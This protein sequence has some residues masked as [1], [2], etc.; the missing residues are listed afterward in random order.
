MNKR[1]QKKESKTTLDVHFELENIFAQSWVKRLKCDLIFISWHQRHSSF[2]SRTT[3]KLLQEWIDWNMY[4]AALKFRYLFHKTVKWIQTDEK[5]WKWNLKVWTGSKNHHPAQNAFYAAKRFKN[6]NRGNSILNGSAF[7]LYNGRKKHFKLSLLST[8]INK[9]QNYL[10]IHY[11]LFFYPLN[12]ALHA[13]L[14]RW[15]PFS[16]MPVPIQYIWK[17]HFWCCFLLLLFFL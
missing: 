12:I 1:R 2:F 11:F 8:R 6:L 5:L 15:W 16:K 17:I 3:K 14:W 10:G 4:R 9:S 13:F 7:R